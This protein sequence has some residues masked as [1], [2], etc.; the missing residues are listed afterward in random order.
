M[1]IIDITPKGASANSYCS[2]AQATSYL[3]TSRVYTTAWDAA[4][5]R[6]PDAEGFLVNGIVSSGATAVPIKS[7]A[8]SFT[9]G[10]YVSFAGHAGE[11][12]IS[13]A[14]ATQL[15]LATALTSS[16]ADDE[17]ITRLTANQREASLI[18][19][20][21]LLDQSMQW[22]GRQRELTQRLRWP[23]S[24]VVDLDN[25]FYDYDTIPEL[26]TNGTAELALALLE[27]N[28]VKEPGILGLG[29]EAVSIGSI[30][31]TASQS[32]REDLIPENVLGMLSPLGL[33]YP[34]FDSG[35]ISLRRG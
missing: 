22:Y 28:R 26:L 20:T 25:D 11:Y 33:L 6:L 32:Q 34:S 29:L 10:G 31:L 14:T 23:R 4:A 19:A 27:K 9:D 15:T 3:R 5:T 8:G 13:T 18:W 21:A 17:A 12:E 35:M 30:R 2:L 1:A 16:L 7:G 24:G